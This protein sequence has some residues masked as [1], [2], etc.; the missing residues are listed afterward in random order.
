MYIAPLYRIPLVVFVFAMNYC[1]AS[2]A[3]HLNIVTGVFPW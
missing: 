3:K 2:T 1:V